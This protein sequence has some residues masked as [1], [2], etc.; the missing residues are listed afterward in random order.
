MRFKIDWASLI[1]GSKFTIFLCFLCI[2][3]QFSSEYKPRG[4]LYLEGWFNGGFF[5]SQ[6]W[7]AYIWRGLYMEG[8]IF[9]ILRYLK[10]KLHLTTPLQNSEEFVKNQAL[11]NLSRQV[12]WDWSKFARWCTRGHDL[13]SMLA[14]IA[15]YH[16]NSWNWKPKGSREN[17]MR[18]SIRTQNDQSRRQ[19]VLLSNRPH[20]LWT[21]R[22]DNPLG[23]WFTSCLSVLPTSRVGY[24]ARKLIESVVYCFFKITLVFYEFTGTINHRFLTNQNARTILVIL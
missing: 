5:A 24:H 10:T 13:C 19:R 12:L 6:D 7:G 21:Y 14:D 9:G 2:W 23:S 3:G 4:S 17:N 8:L 16:L 1:V 20:F 22:G 11:I 18:G 15:N